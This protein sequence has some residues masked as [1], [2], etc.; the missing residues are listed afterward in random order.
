[1]PTWIDAREALERLGS[2]PQT[3]YANVSRGRIG[4]RADPADSRRSLYRAA[5]VDRLA[6]RR[7]GRRSAETVARDAVSWGDPVLPSAISTIADGRLW[8]RGQDAARLSRSA[9]LEEVAAL[10]WEADPP[11]L[12]RA[13]AVRGGTF[14]A[15]LRALADRAGYDPP[16]HGR[17]SAVLKREAG[18]VLQLLATVLAGAGNGPLHERLARKWRR[19]AAADHL[20]RALVLLA[21]HELNASTFAVRVVISTGASLAAGVLGGLVALGGPLHGDASAGIF[22]LAERAD[23]IGA[24]AAT[25]E[26]LEQGRPL[27]AF[28]HPLYPAGDPRAA[29]LLAATGMPARYAALAAVAE[30]LVGEA[31]NVDFALAAL[32]ETHELPR[33]AP[34]ALFALARATGWLAHALEQAAAGRLIRPRAR[35]VGAPVGAAD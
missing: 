15:A 27:P 25:R 21:D 26:C 14:A 4:A 11:A 23:A 10:L 33:E 3:L 18:E 1:M 16:S 9:C 19:P 8:Y 24:E 35:Y 31:P 30:P 7:R 20:R 12:A 5:D 6:A 22:A 13:S 34:L 2:K 28:G 17:S 32:A 29:E